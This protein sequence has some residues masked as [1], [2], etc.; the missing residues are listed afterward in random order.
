MQ[1]VVIKICHTAY[2]EPCVQHSHFTTLCILCQQNN[3]SRYEFLEGNIMESDC[4]M[5]TMKKK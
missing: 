3:F 4:K 1:D 5:L 2:C